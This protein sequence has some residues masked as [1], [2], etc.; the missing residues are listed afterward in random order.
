MPDTPLPLS[1]QT[2]AYNYRLLQSVA[3]NAQSPASAIIE[4]GMVYQYLLRDLLSGHQAYFS[5]DYERLI[6]L[7]DYYHLPPKLASGLKKT[8]YILSTTARKTSPEVSVHDLRQTVLLLCRVIEHFSG[9]FPPTGLY[10]FCQPLLLAANEEEDKKGAFN[11]LEEIPL[12][13]AVVL[14]I[15]HLQETGD[16]KPY[17]VLTCATT[18]FD[19]VEVYLWDKFTYLQPLLWQYARLNLTN[20]Q[21]KTP[22]SGNKAALFAATPQT[23]ITLDPD[24]LL[25]V[26]DLSQ[27]CI[28][29]GASYAMYL[30]KKFAADAANYHLLRGNMVNAWLDAWLRDK[31]PSV[32]DLFRQYIQVNPTHALTFGNEEFKKLKEE[33]L[34][35]TGNI[36]QSNLQAYKKLPLNLE[37]TF[38][39]DI[40]GLRGRL[41]ILVNYPDDLHHRD[42]IELK[43]SKDPLPWRPVHE[44]DAIQA[45]SY[46]LLLESVDPLQ[47]GSSAILYSAVPPHENPLRNV[48]NDIHAKQ[49]IL[50]LRNKIVAAE[51]LLTQQPET[52]LK[53]VNP[54]VVGQDNLF[55]KDIVCLNHF[56]NQLAAATPLERD[57]FYTWVAFAA[58]EHR[59]SKIGG[60]NNRGDRGFSGLWNNELKFKEKEFTILAFLTFAGLNATPLDIELVFDKTPGYTLDVAR[61]RVGDMVLLYPHEPNNENALQP[62]QHQILKATIK[63]LGREQVVI[64]PMNK[65][66]S[67]DYFTRWNY[68]AFEAEGTDVGYEAMYQ[69]LY[70][71]LQLPPQKKQLLLGLTP[72]GFTPY[73][74]TIQNPQLKPH[75]MAVLK[76]ALAAQDYFL[77]QGPPG[78]GKTKVMMRQLVTEILKNPDEKIILLAY[79]NRAVDEMC[80]ALQNL[81]KEQRIFRLGYG[82]STEHPDLLL[83]RFAKENELRT[84]KE[85]IEKCRIFIATVLTWQRSPEL[86]RFLEDKTKNP[87]LTAIIDE[88]SQLLEPQIIGVLGKVDRFILIGDEKQLPAVVIQ[89]ETNIYTNSELLNQTG[90][91]NLSVSLFER[92]LQRCKQQQWQDA[93]DMLQDQGRMHVKIANYPNAYYY[94]GRLRHIEERQTANFAT[95]VPGTAMQ[96]EWPFLETL[97]KQRTIF[98]ATRPEN[99][100]N[101]NKLEAMLVNRLVTHLLPLFKPDDLETGIGII[102]P[103]RTQIAEIKLHLNNTDEEGRIVVDTVERYQGGQKNIIIVSLAVND[104]A[105][106]KNLHVLN[107]AGNVDKKLNVTLT[108]AKEYLIL[109]GCTS[110]LENSPIYKPLIEYYR[111]NGALFPAPATIHL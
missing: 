40:Y 34:Q 95:F 28:K 88:A 55:P 30:Y 52:A 97:W 77:L 1:A 79:T 82:S 73:A 94:E 20:L 46:Y 65:H 15:G 80:E 107:E 19:E 104:P 8:G 4:A 54:D 109:I 101:R 64:S 37:P 105:Q 21:L 63:K 13:K 76:K 89:G 69:A 16:A 11:I 84:T 58:R 96:P 72:P 81:K 10:D 98:L 108:R 66:I 51:F 83:S 99:E 22:A 7:I 91:H 44:R 29:K 43:T 47:T 86:R 49:Q 93:F 68:W 27:A 42:V 61:F 23:L 59:A 53:A 31:N 24:F 70:E 71:F 33:V 17:F 12:L 41:D 9:V 100:R 18:G 57:Y 36:V 74:A 26:T 110:V 85:E 2:A 50:E 106:L 103:Y 48:P 32:L 67:P 62:M 90:I 87:R 111:N 38:L 39:S 56:K 78:T 92:L 14:K 75:Q 3:D 45:V 5:T 35:H 60:D 102:T 6:V 25:D